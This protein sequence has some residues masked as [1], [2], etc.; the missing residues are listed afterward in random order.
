VSEPSATEPV[1]EP[2]ATSPV[3]GPSSAVV[4]DTEAALAAAL[5]SLGQAHHRP[6]S[7]A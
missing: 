4:P 2:S 5:D 7:R 1:A 3:A 6:Y